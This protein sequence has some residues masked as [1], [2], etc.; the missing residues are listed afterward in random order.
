MSGLLRRLLDATTLAGPVADVRVGA[1]WTLVA[2]DTARGSRAGLASTQVNHDLEHGA[3]SVRDAGRLIGKPA[4]ELAEWV[5][6]ESP[7]ERSI[8]FATL[9]ALLEVDESRCEPLNAEAVILSHGAGKH[10]A[11][12]GHFPFTERARAAAARLSVLELNPQPGDLPASAAAAVIPDADVVAIT[13]M[14]LVNGTF[15]SL[16]ALAKPGAFTLLLGATTPLSPILFDY[17]IDAISGT[18]IDDVR[19]ASEAVSQGSNFR[20]VAGKRLLTM[21]KG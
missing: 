21:L 5:L 11:I 2:V 12:V 16:A 19:S 20:Q 8:G 9:N 17:G 13:G 18:V 1:H 6:A 3:P 14:T 15:E 10:I 7:T 4:R